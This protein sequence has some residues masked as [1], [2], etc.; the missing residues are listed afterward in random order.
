MVECFLFLFLHHDPA[1]R[2]IR[3]SHALYHPLCRR[4]RADQ[5][6]DGRCVDLRR[7]V[8]ASFWATRKD[9]LEQWRKSRS[10]NCAVELADKVRADLCVFPHESFALY[11]DAKRLGIDDHVAVGRCVLFPGPRC[12]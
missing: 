6:P 11:Q 8:G 10:S 1:Q 4:S 7:A 5:N 12:G 3:S 9:A 2:P